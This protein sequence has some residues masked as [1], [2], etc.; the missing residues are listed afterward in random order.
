MNSAK[1]RA[2]ARD[3]RIAARRARTGATPLMTFASCCS[4]GIERRGREPVFAIG[5][6]RI[7]AESPGVARV[8]NASRTARFV[9]QSNGIL[10]VTMALWSR[11]ASVASIPMSEYDPFTDMPSG[12]PRIRNGMEMENSALCAL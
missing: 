7:L 12:A 1:A 3:P 4:S 2:A 5:R 10:I 6:I 8:L 9:F 11:F